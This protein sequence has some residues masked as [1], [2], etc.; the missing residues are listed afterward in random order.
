MP[1]RVINCQATCANLKRLV[2]ERGLT[3]KDIRGILNRDSSQSV[4]KW[5]ATARGK[6][7]SIPSVDNLII[8]AYILEVTLDEIYVTNEVL[9]EVKKRP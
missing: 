3:P 9:Y 1:I 4:D 6:G 5:Y 7:T 8:L 2:E